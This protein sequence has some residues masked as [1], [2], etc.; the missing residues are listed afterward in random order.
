MVKR[1]VG[2]IVIILF[3]CLAGCRS[4]QPGETATPESA[5]G[6]SGLPQA[7]SSAAQDGMISIEE[8]QETAL[9]KAF[10]MASELNAEN[11]RLDES[12]PCELMTLGDTTVWAV[13]FTYTI[14]DQPDSPA[15]YGGIVM[16]NA[17]SGEV[18][19]VNLCA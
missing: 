3:C 1:A 17:Y 13:R 9:E 19:R 6:P 11:I 7:T 18:F 12:E 10:S 4:A 16:V 8:A 15:F 2:L 5:S 14:K